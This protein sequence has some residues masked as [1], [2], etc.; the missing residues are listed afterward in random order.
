MTLLFWTFLCLLA[1]LGVQCTNVIQT[2]SEIPPNC[3]TVTLGAFDLA[4]RELQYID[5]VVQAAEISNSDAESLQSE[6]PHCLTDADF[7]EIA[8]IVYHCISRQLSD[9][10]QNGLLSEQDIR[11]IADQQS[12][13]IFEA[14]R[15]LDGR[16]DLKNFDL[17]LSTEIEIEVEQEPSGFSCCIS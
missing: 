3:C 17:N 11:R 14:I 2:E 9:Y 8:A 5:Q 7:E 10:L 13:Q 12:T 15:K 4:C 6:P 1:V 16:V